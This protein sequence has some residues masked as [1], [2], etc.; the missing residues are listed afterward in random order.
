MT[1]GRFLTGQRVNMTISSRDV[2]ADNEK[3]PSGR[4]RRTLIFAGISVVTVASLFAIGFAPAQWR[5][6]P[7][8]PETV[9]GRAIVPSR[10]QA[11]G[12]NP[13]SGEVPFGL[14]PDGGF[15]AFVA[16]AGEET[17]VWIR[18]L[19]E[20]QAVKV[21]GTEGAVGKP[22]WSPDGRALAYFVPQ[23]LEAVELATGM[24]RTICEVPTGRD[25]DGAWG[26]DAILITRASG[27]IFCPAAGGAASAHFLVFEG[28]PGAPLAFPSHP[29][30]L[31]DGVH[32]VFT[33]RGPQ[34]EHNGVF[35]SMVTDELRMTRARRLQPGRSAA[36][37]IAVT[38]RH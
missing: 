16:P 13:R 30:F 20:Q 35:V 9:I 2:R 15:V 25:S 8:T 7:S 22:F 36:A 1:S 6:L 4:P 14:S 32:F 19:D 17:A 21:A 26:A 29:R 24:A 31:P 3:R 27:P 11:P 28:T 18:P 37:Y 34:A 10:A 38:A 12:P 5:E 33:A 23:R